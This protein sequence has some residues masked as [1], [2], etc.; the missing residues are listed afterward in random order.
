MERDL[1]P[2]GSQHS[3]ATDKRKGTTFTKESHPLLLPAQ[4][5]ELELYCETCEELICLHCTVNKHC[6]PQHNYDLVTDTFHRHKTDL[7]TSLQ[8][9]DKLRSTVSNAIKQL[10]L[11]SQQLNDQRASTKASIRQEMK[12]LHEFIEVREAELI[13][14][15]DQYTDVKLENL[16]AQK[17]E[18]EIVH[19][20]LDTCLRGIAIHPHNKNMY[21]VDNNNHRIQV[22]NN[23]LTFS[24]SF[25]SHGSNNGQLY[26]PWDVAVDSTGN[27][28]VAEF[29]NHRIQ[30]FTSEGQFLRKF[31]S[32]GKGNGKLS[33]PAR[34]SIDCDNVVYVTDN[35]DRFSVFTCEGKFLISFG[36]K[37]SGLRQ[38]NSSDGIAIDKN[39]VVHVHDFY[40][41]HLQLF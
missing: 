2:R 22:F 33:S 9:V 3:T 25:G 11:R 26:F 1:Q 8:P 36:S 39:G 32:H 31:W 27:V 18:L 7:T 30:I 20:Q 41:N 14:Q 12:R 21:V 5:K 4:G 13:V 10:D 29:C 40:N 19:T 35:N 23:D 38:F 24:S 34:I 28:Y 16:A 15:V 17:K 6:R 37:G